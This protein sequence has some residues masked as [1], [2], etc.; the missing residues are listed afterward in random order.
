V[1]ETFTLKA[2]GVHHVPTSGP[3]IL[4]ANYVSEADPELLQSAITRRIHFE[5]LNER[6]LDG[7]LIAIFPESAPARTGSIETFRPEVEALI[8]ATP[9]AVVIPAAICSLGPNAV[10]VLLVG[11]P[12]KQKMTAPQL[13]RRIV[14]LSCE[15]I[16]HSQTNESTLIHRFV[17]IARKKWNDPAISDSS[18][19]RLSFGELLTESLLLSQW[20]RSN[21]GVHEQN[22]GTYL[23]A[24]IDA[25]IANCAATLAAKTAVNLNFAAGEQTARLAAE[26]CNLKTILTSKMFLE[27][28]GL[29][30]WPEMVFLEDVYTRLTNADRETALG[31]ARDA[32][33]GHLAKG[34]APD[35]TACILFSSGS[36]GIPKGAQLTHW[37]ILTNVAGL[38]AKIPRL[39][40]D[41]VLGALPFFHSF[42]YTF[43]LWYPLLEGVRAAYHSSPIDAK[44]IGDLCETHRATLF[45]STP[46]F[47]LQYAR[48]VRPAQFAS[49]K[50]VLVGAEKLRDSVAAEF[51]RHFG[52]DLLAGYGCTELGPGVAVNVPDIACDGFLHIGTRAGSVG[53]PLVGIT[54][55]IVDPETRECLPTGAQGLVLVNGPSRMTG[56]FQQPDLTANVME[57]GYYITG[58]IGY[59]DDDGFLYIT[60]RLA[61]FSK[62]GG[63]MV[64]HLR[65]EEAVS[66]LTPA[67]ITGVPDNARGER[68]VMIYTNPQ[69]APADLLRELN[70]SGLPPLWVPK[71]GDIQL[72][73]A[74][75]VLPS[76]KVHLA[77]AR[78]LAVDVTRPPANP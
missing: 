8:A 29:S 41:C 31:R 71:R 13:R 5:N 51:R 72:V 16:Q 57:D 50:H 44:T 24:G 58:D 45:L 43:A 74:I 64:P 53:R 35:S 26:Q 33:A 32:S 70:R 10:R 1:T 67:F 9:S 75:P 54:L 40:D 38:A 20:L 12:L 6:L 65:I 56:Y 17:E 77:E 55:R 42:G 36:T 46:T 22:I 48:K 7:E 39:P 52:F 14:E 37:N 11:E 62:I 2:V 34:V 73:S 60:D 21:T 69:I 30:Q 27:R 25:A 19:K 18:Q 3:A 47:C 61:R 78:K 59:V 28:A 23:A 63:E 4:V 15:G 49:L 68:L 66:H 76:G